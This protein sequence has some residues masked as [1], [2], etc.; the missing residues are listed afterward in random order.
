MK[1]PYVDFPSQ[2][3]ME[4]KR[5]MARLD[6]TLS[7]GEHI[8]G[9]EVSI[10]ESKLASL[11]GVRHAIGVA[12]GTDA[13]VMVLRAL[14]IGPGDEVI[15]APNSFV[16]SASSIALT[17]AVPAFADV[18][19]DQLM[20][21]ASL[22]RAITPRTKAIIPVHLT[23][24]ICDMES[25]LSIAKR[26]GLMVIEDAAQAIG[27]ER[28]RRRAGSFGIAGCFSFHPLKNLNA[29]GDAGGIV[30]DNDA[31]ADKLRL[32]RNHGLKSREEVLFWGYNSRLDAIQAAILNIRLPA[33]RSV[34]SKRR[35]NAATYRKGLTGV[36]ECPQDDADAR[37]VYHLFVIQCDRRDQLKDFLANAGIATAVHY[38]VPIHL[39]PASAGLRIAR[40]AFPETERQSRRILS[41]PIHQNLTRAQIDYVVRK[42]REFYGRR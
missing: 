20:D 8:L 32:M 33:L 41:L 12:N 38:P 40:G 39:Q 22:E 15:T 1:V 35:R 24:K 16:A 26:H 29:A 14:G 37:D 34:V 27:A 25:I 7:R 31:L 19:G 13:L 21:P 42:I 10:F 30:T 11:C 4:R 2:Y 6:K 36:V 3:A 28:G 17:G 9:T 5:L 18:K 23:G